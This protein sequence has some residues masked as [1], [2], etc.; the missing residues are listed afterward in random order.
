MY[1]VYILTVKDG[2][3]YIGATSMKPKARW[4]H[5]NGYRHSPELWEVICRDGWES[6][7]AQV[8]MSG[9]TEEEASILEQELIDRY[10]TVEPECGFNIEYGGVNSHKIISDFSRAKMSAKQTG[11]LNNN[12]GKH[13]SEAHKRK[14]AESNRG[15]KRSEETCQRIGKAKEKAVSQYSMSGCFLA[16]YESG[17]TAEKITG[18]PAYAISKAC[19]GVHSQAGGYLWKFTNQ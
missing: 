15:Q 12:Y 13:F 1:S 2:R 5:G 10:H 9:L 19:R 6:I 11:V 7:D 3:K 8:V 18:I 16:T 4:N 17:R 14:I